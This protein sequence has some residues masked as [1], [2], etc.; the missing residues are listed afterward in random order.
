[1][2]K[3]SVHVFPLKNGPR[4]ACGPTKPKKHKIIDKEFNSI[5]FFAF[6]AVICLMNM[7]WRNRYFL[8]AAAH[9]VL[10]GINFNFVVIKWAIYL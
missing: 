6:N 9:V 5:Q 7:S 2:G 1:M 8:V 10:L 3:S 4:T